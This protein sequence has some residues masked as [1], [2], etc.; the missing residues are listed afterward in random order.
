M[1]QDARAVP[2]TLRSS[3]NASDPAVSWRVKCL[4]C[5]AALV[6]QFCAECGQRALPPHPTVQE[7]VGDAVSE[8]SG[9]D[10]KFAETVRLLVARPG[11]LTFE[12][13]GRSWL[14]C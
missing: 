2:P 3:A 14:R 9:W 6:G 4:N 8:F 10:G 5:G 13:G 7:L 11:E 1:I 12:V